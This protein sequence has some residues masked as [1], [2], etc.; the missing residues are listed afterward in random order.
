[1]INKAQRL[2]EKAGGEFLVGHHGQGLKSLM[3]TWRYLSSIDKNLPRQVMNIFKREGVDFGEHSLKFVA[4]LAH[5]PGDLTALRKDW[6]SALNTVDLDKIN[7]N[8]KELLLKT[9]AH[10]INY[11]GLDQFKA[12][13]SELLKGITDPR[14]IAEKLKPFIAANTASWQQAEAATNAIIK[15][16][17]NNGRIEDGI[18]LKAWDVD[19]AVESALRDLPVIGVTNPK[20]VITKLDKP[21]IVKRSTIPSNLNIPTAEA[22][23]VGNSIWR[24]Q[25]DTLALNQNPLAN[26]LLETAGENLS[27]VYRGA[28]SI[29]SDIGWRGAA[30][31]ATTALGPGIGI[32]TNEWGVRDDL[33]AGRYWQAG[34][35]LAGQEAIGWAAVES[36]KAFLRT[37]LGVTVSPL[38]LIHI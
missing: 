9:Q 19:G 37:P 32:A 12:D 36:G 29:A 28:K 17:F 10:K 14:Q 4:T 11:G 38:T 20:N 26:E 31:F 21:S 5:T 24:S 6:K 2:A 13:P 33:G 18:N 3:P 35:K 16:G 15:H 27:N 8:L 23:R 34:A 1:M 30:D 22:S 7:P 25:G